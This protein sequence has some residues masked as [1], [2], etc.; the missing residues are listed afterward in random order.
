M[1]EKYRIT[2]DSD[3]EDALIMQTDNGIIK[4]SRTPEVIY[5]Y[6]LSAIYLKHV[7]ETKCMSPPTE[8]SG[9]QLR[10]MVSTAT[11]NRKDY[12]QLQFKNS[13]RARR[14]Y[15]IVGCP[16]VENFKHILRQNIIRNCPVTIGDVNIADK[17]YGANIG[18]LKC[19]TNRNMPTPVNNDLV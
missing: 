15:H 12:T 9:T 6:K 1:T 7:A 2:Y 19:K 8:T 10:N 18:A 13:K 16:T 5:S 3:K 4:F 14:L 17:I 11:E